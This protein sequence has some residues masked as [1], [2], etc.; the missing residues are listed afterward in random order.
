MNSHNMSVLLT[1]CMLKTRAHVCTYTHAHTYRETGGTI[2]IFLQLCV[3]WCH[4]I[5]AH[6]RLHSQAHSYSL[7]V[8]RHVESRPHTCTA[9]IQHAGAK[10]YVLCLRT[11]T[12]KSPGACS[13]KIELLCRCCSLDA[14]LAMTN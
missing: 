9:R 1:H 4:T 14:S 2:I 7:D 3:T 11:L 8:E 12:E 5:A 6:T 13:R 10:P